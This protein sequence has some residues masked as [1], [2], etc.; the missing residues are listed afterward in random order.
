MKKLIMNHFSPEDVY[1][2]SGT[3]EQFEKL[4]NGSSWYSRDVTDCEGLYLVTNNDEYIEAYKVNGETEEEVRE[5]LVKEI[6][7]Q[8][9]DNDYF[10]ETGTLEFDELETIGSSFYIDDATDMTA[11]DVADAVMNWIHDSYVDCDSSSQMLFMTFHKDEEGTSLEEFMGE[12]DYDE[13][14]D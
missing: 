5:N 8:M 1:E 14:E 3:K 6:S 11:E 9:K 4:E 7:E 13:D 10:K 12:E 2:V